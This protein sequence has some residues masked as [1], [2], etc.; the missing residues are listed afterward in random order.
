MGIVFLFRARASPARV[1]PVADVEDDDG[2]D[3]GGDH[4]AGSHHGEESHHGRRGASRWETCARGER[5]A[6]ARDRRVLAAGGARSPGC[7]LGSRRAVVCFMFDSIPDSKRK[8]ARARTRGGNASTRW[9]IPREAVTFRRFRAPSGAGAVAGRPRRHTTRARA[10]G[11]ARAIDRA[12]RSRILAGSARARETRRRARRGTSVAAPSPDRSERENPPSSLSKK[13]A[14]GRDGADAPRGR[15]RGLAPRAD[16]GDAALVRDREEVRAVA[17]NGRPRRV[18]RERVP[19]RARGDPR[20]AGAR[21]AAPVSRPDSVR[22]SASVLHARP[23]SRSGVEIRVRH[24]R[25]S[26]D[27]SR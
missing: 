5:E 13:N 19:L 10:V 20:R 6:E 9:H 4:L 7:A 24:A 25:S 15:R 1:A 23:R 22:E 14:S 17:P 26:R 18:R 16:V 11:R 8:T 12:A 21:S 3:G 27:F 2:V